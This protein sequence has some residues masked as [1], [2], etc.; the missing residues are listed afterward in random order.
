[1][2]SLPKSDAMRLPAP[3]PASS[4]LPTAISSGP[5]DLSTPPTWYGPGSSSHDG[6]QLVTTPSTDISRTPTRPAPMNAF[7]RSRGTRSMNQRKTM[8][9]MNA[10]G[11]DTN[12]ESRPDSSAPL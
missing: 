4:Q 12:A 8:A 1:M 9:A 10:E 2:G 5:T 6:G 7:A 3:S 11:T